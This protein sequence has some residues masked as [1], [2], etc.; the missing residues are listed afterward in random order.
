M[1]EKIKQSYVGVSGVVSPEMQR[2]LEAIAEDAG[3]TKEGRILALGVKATHKTQ[4]LGEEN[5][6]G[7][8]F[9]PV[10]EAAFHRALAHHDKIPSTL[11]VAQTY[12]DMDLVGDGDYRENFFRQIVARGEPWLQ[13]VQFDMLPWHENIKTLD[14]LKKTKESNLVSL[15]QVHD[16]A[17]KALGPQGVVQ[18]LG[19]YAHLIDYLLFDSS[20]GTGTKLD[21]QALRPFIDTAYQHLDTAQ[22]GIALAGGLNASIIREELPEILQEFPHVSWDAEGQLHPEKDGKDGSRVL[23]L[24]LS[25]EYLRASADVIRA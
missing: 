7:A 9:Y 18:R 2:S 16:G 17:M 3:L 23:D 25:E 13:A 24:P 21:T 8:D 6:Y 19:S 15:L 4:Y 12:F 11:G 14:L 20:H 22:T 10:G 1:S 5:K